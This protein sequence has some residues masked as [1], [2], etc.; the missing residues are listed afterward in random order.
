MQPVP[1]RKLYKQTAAK[2]VL[3]PQ[4]PRLHKQTKATSVP[5]PKTP[6]LVRTTS[7]VS[8]PV[9]KIPKPKPAAVAAPNVPS[10]GWRSRPIQAAPAAGPVIT[11]S[12]PGGRGS[13]SSAGGAAGGA[14]SGGA[15]A[16][17]D[18]SKVVEAVKQLAE[19]AKKTKAAGSTKGI[20]Q[21][22]RTYTD[23]RKTTVAALRSLKSKRIREFNAKTKKLPKAERTKQRRE[24]KQKVEAQFKEALMKFPTARGLKSV[25]VIR[26]LIRKLAAFKAAK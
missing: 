15:R 16:A 17:P 22:R 10:A 7:A 3:V 11:V 9:P 5:V 1:E 14:A 12:A 2:S 8:A 18:M 20:T 19:S 4:Q 24:Y 21:A 13:S 26:D 6:R 25:G 23:K